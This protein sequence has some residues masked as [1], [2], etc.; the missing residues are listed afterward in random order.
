[1]VLILFLFLLL[2]VLAILAII[3]IYLLVSLLPLFL[4]DSR[5]DNLN[6]RITAAYMVVRLHK[7]FL[8]NPC[9]NRRHLHSVLLALHRGYCGQEVGDEWEMLY[10]QSAMIFLNRQL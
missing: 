8:N 6:N 10:V 5:F 9:H 7:V 3:S 4:P 2:V 1:M